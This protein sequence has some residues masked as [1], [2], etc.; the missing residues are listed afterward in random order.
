MQIV[1]SGVASLGRAVDVVLG[2]LLFQRSRILARKKF[3]PRKF[4]GPFQ[5]RDRRIVPYTLEVRVAP[6][7]NGG[8]PSVGAD[9]CRRL[10]L[11]KD[12]GSGQPHNR[13]Q[14]R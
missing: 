1:E 12:E 7:R 6:R 9:I 10:D 13:D 3:F 8:G 11:T 5:R 14:A 4:I 2:R